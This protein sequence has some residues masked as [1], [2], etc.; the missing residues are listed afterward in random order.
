[1]AV[2]KIE[3]QRIQTKQNVFVLFWNWGILDLMLDSRAGKIRSK[4]VKKLG[5]QHLFGRK[6]LICCVHPSHVAH[7]ESLHNQDPAAES[8]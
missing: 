4:N 5:N 8:R 2:G 7:L 3:N 6:K 1:M